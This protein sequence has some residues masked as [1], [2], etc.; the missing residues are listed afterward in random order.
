MDFNMDAERKSYC[1]K[2]WIATLIIFA[3]NDN[4][5]YTASLRGSAE[6]INIKKFIFKLLT[7]ILNIV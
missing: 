5:I 3:R 7:K 6:A 4:S 2:N 1:I